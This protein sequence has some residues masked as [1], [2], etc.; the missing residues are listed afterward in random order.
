M[1][2]PLT[3][4]A[5]ATLARGAITARDIVR[6]RREIAQAEH[7]YAHELHAAAVRCERDARRLE[8]SLDQPPG[9]ARRQAR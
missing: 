4:P 3:E 1:A 6:A 9:V 7:V 8:R 5:A 2:R